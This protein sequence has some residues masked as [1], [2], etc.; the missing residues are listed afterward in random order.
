MA[1]A[2]WNMS[3]CFVLVAR[4][5]IFSLQTNSRVRMESSQDHVHLVMS[6]RLFCSISECDCCVCICPN[7]QKEK[8]GKTPLCDTTSPT[9]A[10]QG[11]AAGVET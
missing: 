1:V 5:V 8:N 2:W 11:E 4:S 10:P 9:V 7:K 6:A 3:A